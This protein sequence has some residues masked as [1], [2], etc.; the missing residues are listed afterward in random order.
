MAKEEHSQEFLERR[1]L[2]KQDEKIAK[3]KHKNK[4]EEFEFMRESSK[5][6]AEEQRSFH[7]LKRA[8]KYRELGIRTPENKY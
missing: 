3:L 2:Q 8:D 6:Q 5:L 1:E 4:M 7:R